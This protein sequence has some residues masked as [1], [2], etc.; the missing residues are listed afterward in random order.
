MKT[1]VIQHEES[2]QPEMQASR[3]RPAPPARTGFRGVV[4]RHSLV[5]FF[6]LTYVL[7]WAMVPAGAILTFGPLL[8]ALIVLAVAEGKPGLADLGRRLVRWRVG[9]RWYVLAIALPLGATLAALGLNLALGAPVSGLDD[10]DPWYLL[11]G[12]FFLRL[13]NPLDGPLGEE[14]G[15][16]GF[17]LPRLQAGRSPLMASL[18]LGLLVAVWHVP[19]VFVDDLAPVYLFATVG[20]TFLYTWI[21]NR[22]GG[23]VFMTL[24]AHSAQGVIAFGALGFTG[25]DDTRMVAFI[26]LAICAL[27]VGLV[28][29]DPQAWRRAPAEC[30]I[31]SSPN[32]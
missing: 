5:A 1:P 22:T 13:V 14:P 30:R 11:V 20:I 24:V 27:A 31:E 16:R 2:Q 19:L 12:L 3:E 17:A 28:V 18:I 21:F 26:T 9:A 15:W 32:S 7:S 6:G 4:R 8:A 23:S 25:A 29:F 10:L